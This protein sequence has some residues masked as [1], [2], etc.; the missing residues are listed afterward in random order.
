[1][2]KIYLGCGQCG[3]LEVTSRTKIA[4]LDTVLGMEVI[5]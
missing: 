3:I 1:M 2:K 5:D 4:F